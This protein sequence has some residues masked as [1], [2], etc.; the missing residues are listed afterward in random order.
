MVRALSFWLLSTHPNDPD[1]VVSLGD[2]AAT[3]TVPVF[4][5]RRIERLPIWIRGIHGSRP[6]A[7]LVGGGHNTTVKVA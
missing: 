2:A 6:D 7:D 1:V 4:S 5:D 3:A